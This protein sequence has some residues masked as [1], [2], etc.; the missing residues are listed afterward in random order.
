MKVLTANRL[1]DGEAVWYAG[2]QRWSEAIADAEVAGDKAAEE[3]LDAIGKAAF[4]AN[5]VLDVELIDVEVQDGAI[6]PNRLR[7]R[8][9]AAG[10]TIRHDLGK[11]ARPGVTHAA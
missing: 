5:Q 10:P 1:I 7:E 9:R 2:G 3:A 8:I 4:A 6:V 11:Q